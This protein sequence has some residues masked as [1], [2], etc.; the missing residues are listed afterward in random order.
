MQVG[1]VARRLLEEG[2]K[3]RAITRKTSSDAAKKLAKQGAEVVQA[4]F[5]DQGSLEMR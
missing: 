2:C 4:S 5:D 3:V 1:S